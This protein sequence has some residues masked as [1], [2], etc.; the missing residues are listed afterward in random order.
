MPVHIPRKDFAPIP[1]CQPNN[2]QEWRSRVIEAFAMNGM[3]DYLFNSSSLNVEKMAVGM[4]IILPS[5]PVGL[6]GY[7]TKIGYDFDAKQ[8]D[9]RKLFTLVQQAAQKRDV[10][11]KRETLL[12]DFY[13]V[14]KNNNESAKEYLQRIESMRESLRQVDMDPSDLWLTRVTLFGLRA[15]PD[16]RS[17]VNQ[18]I[19]EDLS[20]NKLSFKTLSEILIAY[21]ASEGASEATSSATKGPAQKPGSGQPPPA[22]GQIHGQAANSQ[23][24][25]SA[26]TRTTKSASKTRLQPTSRGP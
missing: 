8:Q 20:A 23:Q 1:V 10:T 9:A 14:E 19:V 7:L 3:G 4:A 13:R 12:Y 21:E 5:L 17:W 2:M 11:F 18:R 25:K 15:Q 24:A 6:R 16:T 26:P 22:Q